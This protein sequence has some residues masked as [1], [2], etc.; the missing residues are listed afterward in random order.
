[1]I[2]PFFHSSKIFTAHRVQQTGKKA[3]KYS[4]TGAMEWTVK[5]FTK[6][7]EETG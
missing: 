7:L 2:V 6:K 4:S 1:M 3:P 5:D